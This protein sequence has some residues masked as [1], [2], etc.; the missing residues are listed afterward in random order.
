MFRNKQLFWESRV[1]RISHEL[2][3]L[4]WFC[5]ILTARLTGLY[6]YDSIEM[7]TFSRIATLEMVHLV[8][9]AAVNK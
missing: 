1:P 8:I 2:D 3:R 9:L 7:Y 4:E 6:V 5:K